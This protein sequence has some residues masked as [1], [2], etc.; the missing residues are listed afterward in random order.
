MSPGPNSGIDFHLPVDLHS[1]QFHF[2]FNIFDWPFSIEME[3]G[4]WKTDNGKCLPTSMWGW[5]G[6]LHWKKVSVD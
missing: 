4:K 1:E 5:Q 3:N 6:V 2:P